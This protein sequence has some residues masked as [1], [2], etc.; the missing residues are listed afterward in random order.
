MKITDIKTR[1]IDQ[2]MF[3]EI[4]TDEGIKGVLI[5]LLKSKK[6]AKEYV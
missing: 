1:F 6:E 3:V 5:V 4:Y 2:F